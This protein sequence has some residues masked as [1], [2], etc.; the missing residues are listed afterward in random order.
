MRTAILLTLG[1]PLL[2]PVAA[3]AEPAQESIRVVTFNVWELGRD[4]LDVVDE[5]GQGR[6]PQLRAA[7]EVVQRLRPDILLINEID[8]DEAGENARLFESRYLAVPQAEGL[9]GLRFPHQVFE[10]T[11]TGVQSG[12][13]FDNNGERG[14]PEDAWGFGR[15]PGQYGMAL[16]SRFPV[17][18]EGIRTFRLL[19]W[20][21]MPGHQMPYGGLGRPE[22]Y[23]GDE[24]A[25]FRLSSKSH[26]DVPIRI[27]DTNVHVLASHPTPPS[28]DGPEDRN[29][30]RNRDEIRLWADY[31]SAG[32]IGA[33]LVDDEGRA[34]G[35]R[36]GT[37]F[38]VMGDLNADPSQVEPPYS[39]PAITQLLEHPRVRD[40]APASAGGSYMRRDGYAGDRAR[41]TS[42]WGRID[43]VLPSADLAVVGSGVFW[44][45]P[46]DP[47]HHLVE[48][49]TRSSDHRAVWVD[50]AVDASG[51]LQRV[52][53]T[54]P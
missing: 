23:D 14:D 47:L 48:G 36:P 16:Y 5:A 41:A 29:G 54:E 30:R 27:G 28:F 19:R 12:F 40:P 25:V 43:Y 21:T 7:A 26:W 46:G 11:N 45:P 35:L 1:C 50:L 33:W 24:A 31:L 6:D 34:G 44:P 13:D 38:V 51:A 32:D 52:A 49:E 39:T 42:H 53:P 15:Y 37:A 2:L 3:P 22:W 18:R 10:P 4:K 9:E 8:Y 20:I 17:D